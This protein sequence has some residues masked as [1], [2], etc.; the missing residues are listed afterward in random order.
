MKN[1]IVFGL[2]MATRKPR[3]MCTR[4]RG[5]AASAAWPAVRQL[6]IPSQTR[7]PPHP[8]QDLKHFGGCLQVPVQAER[9]TCEQRR[10]AKRGPDDRDKRGAAA[11][12]SG[13]RDHQSDNRTRHAYQDECDEQEG[14]EQVV[15]H[16]G[17]VAGGLQ[18]IVN[19]LAK[20]P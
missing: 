3:D 14:R 16:G 18:A 7:R 9:D 20:C 10:I 13:C 15:I 5:G 12:R 19:L 6:W 8:A 17:P 11:A 2:V 1:A 4:W